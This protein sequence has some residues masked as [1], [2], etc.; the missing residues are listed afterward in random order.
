MPQRHPLQSK[1]EP[2]LPKSPKRVE[3]PRLKNLEP[4]LVKSN[5]PQKKPLKATKAK[6]LTTRSSLK[7]TRSNGEKLESAKP[8]GPRFSMPAFKFILSIFLLISIVSL[9]M[10]NVA[11][12]PI[13][14]YNY[15]FQI[16]AIRLPLLAVVFT[17]LL[18]GFLVAWTAGTFKQAKLRSQLK[19]HEKTIWQMREE[20]EKHKSR[21]T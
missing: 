10:N 9:A 2:P 11:V 16:Q 7:T 20:L 1:N 12:V 21:E 6:R 4:M 5:W 14:Y 15:Q 19:K 8:V 13:Q 18:M 3:K 17:C